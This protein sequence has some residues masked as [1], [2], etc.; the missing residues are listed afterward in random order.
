[1]ETLFKHIVTPRKDIF[2]L[3]TQ[4]CELESANL[5]EDFAQVDMEEITK[6]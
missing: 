2:G 1:M 3:T 4:D 5:F 6:S